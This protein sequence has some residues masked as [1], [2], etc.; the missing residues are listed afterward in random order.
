MK[1]LVSSDHPKGKIRIFEKFVIAGRSGDDDKYLT[2][3]IVF[4]SP[5]FGIF[6]HE[7]HRPDASPILH[8][9]PW[10]FASFVL[11][12]SYIERYRDMQRSYQNDPA[13]LRRIRRFNLKRLRDA[14]YIAKLD[15]TPTWTLVFVGKTERV[16]GYWEQVSP[17]QTL[18]NDGGAI[19]GPGTW[20]RTLWL[21][22]ENHF[23]TWMANEVSGAGYTS[24]R[25]SFANEGE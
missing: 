16:W 15:R 9:H 24:G 18:I 7:I 1:F 17:A 21:A 4:D 22:H 14:H 10:P 25:D 3:R 20:Y 6:L 11:R 19:I 12:G 8:D 23:P 2:R 5:W 13:Q